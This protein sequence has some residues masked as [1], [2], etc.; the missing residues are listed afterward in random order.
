MH[1]VVCI[2]ILLGVSFAHT[3]R[4]ESCLD[5]CVLGEKEDSA[6]C[7]LW[8]DI[9]GT[10]IDNLEQ[11]PGQMHNR[12]RMHSAWLH[13]FMLP[14][15]GVANAQMTDDS[16][17]AVEVYSGARDPAIWTGALLAAESLRL[18][19]TGAPDAA[20]QVEATLKTLHRWW[21][22]S[23]DQGYLARYVAP[24]NSPPEIQAMF[25]FRK[26]EVNFDV[27]FEGGHYHWRGRVSRDQY[28]GVILGYGLAYEATSDPELRELIRADVLAFTERLM[29][30]ERVPVT[31]VTPNGDYSIELEAEHVVYTDDETPDGLPLVEITTDPFEVKASG[32]LV[33]WPNL[34]EY[35]KAVPGFRWLPDVY[36]PTQAFQLAAAFAVALRVTEGVPGYEERYRVLRRHYEHHIYDWL[37]IAARWRNTNRCGDSYFGLNIAFMPAFN[38]ARLEP[39]LW[40]RAFVRLL[41]ERRLWNEVKDHKN[42]FFA[43]IAASQ[44]LRPAT[45]S[46]TAEE[47]AWQLDLFPPAPQLAVPVDLRGIYPEDPY[48]PDLSAIA[49]D[50]DERP[51]TTFTWERPPWTLYDPGESNRIYPGVDYL[52][53]Y[54]MG[55][56]FGF[57]GDDASGT[58]L[59]WDNG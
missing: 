18:M 59:L 7:R 24:A 4:A 56:Y 16:L 5:V 10:W 37:R 57:I 27:P 46:E 51:A 13:A 50:L 53:A 21:R 9:T 41:L 34:T 15:G 6:T 12:A 28:Q 31:I 20:R 36:S 43:F 55:R 29:R 11:G 42:A 30:R 44:A 40:R 8:D 48:C 14:A 38:W 22:I 45:L 2:V 33:F 54:W 58:C 52:L 26:E 1:F 25:E 23:G 47:H 3:S 35:L 39:S 19:T 49:V 32:A 17:S